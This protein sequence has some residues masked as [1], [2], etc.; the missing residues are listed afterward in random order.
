MKM[1]ACEALGEDVHDQP[2]PLRRRPRDSMFV[3]VH[4]TP[5][6]ART[7]AGRSPGCYVGVTV[8]LSSVWNWLPVENVFRIWAKRI[9]FAGTYFFYNDCSVSLMRSLCFLFVSGN[10][11]PDIDIFISAHWPSQLS[12]K[13]ALKLRWLGNTSTRFLDAKPIPPFDAWPRLASP[14][15]QHTPRNARIRPIDLCK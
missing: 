8:A 9:L 3:D 5:E 11:E 13:G 15:K 6:S 7:R 4:M 1:M 2:T 10:I 14:G 12:L